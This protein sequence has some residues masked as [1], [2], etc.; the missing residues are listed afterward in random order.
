MSW[1]C[2]FIPRRENQFWITASH[3]RSFPEWFWTLPLTGG[4]CSRP[5]AVSK[6][7][8]NKT[9]CDI[10]RWQINYDENNC[11]EFF[12][13]NHHIRT[14]EAVSIH[15][16]QYKASVFTPS[17][18]FLFYVSDISIPHSY[19]FNVTRYQRIACTDGCSARCRQ[20]SIR[21]NHRRHLG[22]HQYDL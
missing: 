7:Q 8:Q 10:F 4:A 17:C 6:R 16:I 14:N 3:F 9:K 20:Q 2:N 13:L 22:L 18:Y 15:D 11:R 21:G 5:A 19:T 1:Y 12:L